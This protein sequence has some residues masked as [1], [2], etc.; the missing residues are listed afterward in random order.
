MRKRLGEAYARAGR[1]AEAEEQLRSAIECYREAGDP[2]GRTDAEERI[3]SLYRDAGRE[4]DAITMYGRMGT[5]IHSRS[6]FGPRL[7]PT[8]P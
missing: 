4:H 6:I 5:D 2:L 8:L 7:D 3:A 1:S